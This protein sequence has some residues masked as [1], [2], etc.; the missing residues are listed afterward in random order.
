MVT[1]AVGLVLDETEASVEKIKAST[2]AAQKVVKTLKVV[3]KVMKV[4]TA[5]VGLA[6]A[7]IS[8]VPGA[9]AKNLKALYDAAAA[10]A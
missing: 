6:A 4:T 8:K 7:I 9:I 2:Q 10:P 5:A 1:K 3:G